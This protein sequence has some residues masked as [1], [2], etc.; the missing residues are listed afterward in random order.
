M[1]LIKVLFGASNR[2]SQKS[3]QP[4]VLISDELLSYLSGS[5]GQR[6]G[7][8]VDAILLG[9]V[10]LNDQFSSLRREVLMEVAQYCVHFGFGIG[11][12]RLEPT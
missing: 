11:P 6:V 5:C 10:S 8:L 9:H 1:T 4:V 12:F 7:H 3:L 2:R